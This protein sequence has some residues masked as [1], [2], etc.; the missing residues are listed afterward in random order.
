[1]LFFFTLLDIESV[2]FCRYNCNRFD[3]DE[4]KKARDAQEVRSGQIKPRLNKMYAL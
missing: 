2:L 4:A 1:M 3:E